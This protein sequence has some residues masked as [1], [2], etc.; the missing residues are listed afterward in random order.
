MLSARPTL[1]CPDRL[2]LLPLLLAGGFMVS[3][4][5]GLDRACAADKAIVTRWAAEV[6][7][8]NCWPEYPRPQLRRPEWLNLNGLWDIAIVPA[9]ADRPAQFPRQILVPFPIES[10]LGRLQGTLTPEDRAWYRRTFRLPAGWAGQRVL[11][12]FGAVDW[13]AQ[14]WVNGA[15]VG[16]HQ[17][18]YTAFS[19]DVTDAVAWT[20]D[21][22]LVVSVADPTN[23]GTQPRGKQQLR[24]EGIWYTPVSGMWQTVW[25]EPVAQ[26]SIERVRIHPDIDGSSVGI[27]LFVRGDLTDNLAATVAV[28]STGREVAVASGLP[29]QKIVVRIPSA[30]RWWPSDPFLYDLRIRLLADGKVV[31]EVESYFGL[32]SITVGPDKNGLTRML[33]NGEPV[34]QFGP[35]DQGYW[36]DGL[37][38]APT[39]EAMKFD[40]ETA[41]RLGFNMVRKHVK[42][43]PARWFY[44]CDR[45]GLLVWQDMPSGDCHAPWPEDGVEVNRSP[46]SAEQFSREL[47]ALVDF[48]YNAPSV[49]V[50]IPF[51]EGWGQFETVNIAKRV[52]SLDPSRL[53]IAA[54]GGNDFGGGDI[55]DDHYYPGPG[56]PP[57]E[58]GRAAVLGEF[59]GFGLP[60]ADHTWQAEENWG[61]RSFRNAEELN[62]AYVE[63]IRRL[64]PLVESNL[65][66]AV[67]TQITDVE[68]EVNGLMTYD[69]EILKLD[70]A[71]IRA[72]H[73]QLYQALPSLTPRERIATSTLAW[74]RFED[75]SAGSALIDVASRM[76]AIGARD[77]SGHNNHLYVASTLSAPKGGKVRYATRLNGGESNSRCLDDSAPSTDDGRVHDLY[78]DPFLSRPHMNVLDRYPFSEWTVEASFALS[79]DGGDQVVVAKG[80]QATNSG[81]A[82]L[83]LGVFGPS[84][85]IEVR[86]RDANGQPRVVRSQFAVAPGDWYHVAA[87]CD[88][89]SLK[90]FV[91]RDG[92]AKYALQGDCEV[93]GPLQRGS[94]TWTVG[95]G[96]H[97]TEIANDFI[98]EIDEVRISTIA[99]PEGDF[100]FAPDK[101]VTRPE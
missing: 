53:V 3:C 86:M 92:D 70:E 93:D 1:N 78:T 16:T 38:T 7:P 17:G 30:R 96:F 54:S 94:G 65:S 95:R 33:L 8:E 84:R 31:D 22:E 79:G 47:E 88:G 37:Y 46:A 35:L 99:L 97:G 85:R 81:H 82:P 101:R 10:R 12:H 51:N 100:L 4:M 73:E 25:L 11:L 63:A 57:S 27:E 74:W 80:G 50:W 19:F 64:R 2:P 59:G 68:I 56:G 41:K 26:Q 87:T 36:P 91:L 5:A 15:S 42:V 52:K 62:Q 60:L 23:M 24:P 69:R 13:S 49:V 98:G 75:A 55:D 44:W 58:R 14:V 77:V 21:N 45:L 61:Y 76:G 43:E 66:A 32:R 20:Q 90:L 71:Q 40:L 34:F 89:K 48:A 28:A 72:A 29:G 6:T 67:Y 9:D 39:D 83:Q 18:G